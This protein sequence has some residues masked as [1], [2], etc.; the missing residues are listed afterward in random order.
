MHLCRRLVQYL[1]DGHCKVCQSFK[2]T[3]DVQDAGKGNIEF[4]N[5]AEPSYDSRQHNDVQYDDAMSTIHAI[6]V[7]GRTVKGAPLNLRL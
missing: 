1:Y 7:E 4:I 2:T 6:T 5:I 3:L